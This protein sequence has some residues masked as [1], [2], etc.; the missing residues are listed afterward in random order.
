MG[1]L[2][3]GSMQ[4]GVPGLSQGNRGERSR[5]R[6]WRGGVKCHLP[7]LPALS[8]AL[9]DILGW[10]CL[11][12]ARPG[13]GGG[14]PA[15]AGAPSPLMVVRS[16]MLKL[17]SLS[18]K[19]PCPWMQ[20]RRIHVR[21]LAHR[22][23]G[24]DGMEWQEMAGK[25]ASGWGGEGRGRALCRDSCL[26]HSKTKCRLSHCSC[27]FRLFPLHPTLPRRMAASDRP[28][29]MATAPTLRRARAASLALQK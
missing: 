4:H 9:R 24:R 6:G 19:A 14:G 3:P 20:H 1:G 29:A 12:L 16:C 17:R 2:G 8:E 26:Q 5:G 28:R 11:P 27:T 21:G 23:M 10:P 15:G 22:F 18:D 13:P 7:E 25:W